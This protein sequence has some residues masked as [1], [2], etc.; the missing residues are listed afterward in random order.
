MRPSKFN[1]E[2]KLAAK[3]IYYPQCLQYIEEHLDPDFH[4]LAKATIMYYLP[5]NILSLPSK[6]DRRL[7]IESIP[8]DCIPSHT[9]HFVKQGVKM[10]WKK[11]KA[12]GIR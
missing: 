10:L 4:D 9:K 6:E 3:K 8:D 5:N 7:A 12:N 2:V 1:A 11:D